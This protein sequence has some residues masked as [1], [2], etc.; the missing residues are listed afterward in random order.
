MKIIKIYKA[1]PDSF[2]GLTRT[3]FQVEEDGGTAYI[4][5]K[6]ENAPQVG[7]ELEGTFS[8]DKGGSR[9]FTKAK[10]E[11]TPAPKAQERQFKADPDK[12]ASIEW[13][14]AIKSAVEAVKDYYTLNLLTKDNKVTSLEE[15]KL[16]IVN[17]AITFAA[18]TVVKPKQTLEHPEEEEVE[19]PP[20]EVYAEEAENP[21]EED[22]I[23]LDDLPF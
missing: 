15:Y 4:F 13:Q 6:P 19:L 7:M 23:N 14:S 3:T 12:Q 22:Q 11:F 5:T 2:Q 20:V 16:D 9:K 1:E 18:V 10:A 17:A 8:M 21:I